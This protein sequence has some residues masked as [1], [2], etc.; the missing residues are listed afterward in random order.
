MS[1][2]KPKVGRLEKEQRVDVVRLLLLKG[3]LPATVARDVSAKWHITVRQGEN[4][5]R[6][7]QQQI[8]NILE[9][10][11]LFLYAE[12]ISH[13][14]DLR[15]RAQAEGDLRAELAA[16]QDEAKLL[17]LYPAELVEIRDWR[18]E[19]RQNGVKDVDGLFEQLVQ[20]A[21]ARAD[22]GGGVGGSA[23]PADAGESGPDLAG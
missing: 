19:A 5:V 23:T 15:R 8:A 21:L 4:Y 2:A 9:I 1:K 14:R 18:E 6:A 11:R 10:D 16:A 7:A 22:E 12:H 13:R 17:K 3:E 20:A